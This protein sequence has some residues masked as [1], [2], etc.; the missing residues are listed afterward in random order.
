MTFGCSF[1]TRIH[2]LHSWTPVTLSN[3]NKNQRQPNNRPD[4][5]S[6]HLCTVLST[7]LPTHR[8]FDWQTLSKCTKNFWIHFILYVQKG[9]GNGLQRFAEKLSLN[10]LCPQTTG[11]PPVLSLEIAEKRLPG[12]TRYNWKRL[13]NQRSSQS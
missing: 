1:L 9:Q 10:G 12:R 4:R 7:Q 6:T 11:E 2:G 13:Q 3:N 8:N 5:F